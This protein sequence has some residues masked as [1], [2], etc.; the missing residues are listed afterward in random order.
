VLRRWARPGWEQEDPDA[1]PAA[2]AALL[3]RLAVV[4]PRL[5]V[6]RV[7][8]VD[9][10][11]SLAGVPALLLTRLPGRPPPR[12]RVATDQALRTLVEWLVEIEAVGEAVREVVQP[13]YPYY[14]IGD[15]APPAATT[16]PD[17]WR[18]A[19]E[20]AADPIPAG[21]TTFIHRDYH[22]G[23]TLW[24]RATLTGIVDWTPA[25]WGPPGAD[26]GHL[27]A[28]IGFDH[29]PAKADTAA[30]LWAAAGGETADLAWWRLRAFLDFIPDA[31]AT[32]EPARLAA[33][34]A[35]LEALL[36]GT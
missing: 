8:A 12:A 18:R 2:E 4:A 25:C 15:L 1:T 32:A 9:A 5:P 11:G 26:I 13:Y 30:R 6:P 29:G 3:Q 27:L 7:V 34:E 14:R 22:A 17:L 10:D 31:A 28:N 36:Q 24:E 20:A 21:P 33:A 35:N 16:R 23:N 19:F